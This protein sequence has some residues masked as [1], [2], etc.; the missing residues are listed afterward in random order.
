MVAPTLATAGF[1]VLH[2][3]AVVIQLSGY[4]VTVNFLILFFSLLRGSNCCRVLYSSEIGQYLA[5]T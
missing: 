1:F 4:G 3:F 2:I 5:K